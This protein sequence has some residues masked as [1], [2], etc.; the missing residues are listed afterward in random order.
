MLYISTIGNI[1]YKLRQQP[2][3]GFLQRRQD[4]MGEVW[5]NV[6]RSMTFQ[7]WELDEASIR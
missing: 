7:Q 4:T 5:D 6:T 2:V 3:F 1:T